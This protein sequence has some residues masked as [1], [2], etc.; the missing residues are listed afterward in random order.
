[1]TWMQG[2]DT[3]AVVEV[4]RAREGRLPVRVSAG[5][6]ARE[7]EILLLPAARA[8]PLWEYMKGQ[9]DPNRP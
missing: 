9:I 7:G 1:M 2:D 6:D 8:V 3:V 5:R 4:G